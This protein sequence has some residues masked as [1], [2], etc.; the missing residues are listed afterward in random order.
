[1]WFFLSYVDFHFLEGFMA[2]ELSL[3]FESPSFL[4]NNLILNGIVELYRKFF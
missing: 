3:F 4:E 2:E 1:M